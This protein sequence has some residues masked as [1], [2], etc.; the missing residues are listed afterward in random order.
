MGVSRLVLLMG[1]MRLG[2]VVRGRRIDFQTL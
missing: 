2:A 1:S